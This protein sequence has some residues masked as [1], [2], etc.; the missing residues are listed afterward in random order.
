MVERIRR[1]IKIVCI[2]CGTH[3][4]ARLSEDDFPY[5]GL[6][7]RSTDWVSAGFKV[8]DKIRCEGCEGAVSEVDAAPSSD[9]RKESW[10]NLPIGARAKSRS[11]APLE[12]V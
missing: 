2:G 9:P 5:G 8:S 10:K 12:S 11:K 3:G 1:R 4:V 6:T 7:C